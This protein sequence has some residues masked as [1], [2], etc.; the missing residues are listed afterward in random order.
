MP[1]LGVVCHAGR[2]HAP[3]RDACVKEAANRCLAR[4]ETIHRSLALPVKIAVVMPPSPISTSPSPR[5]RLPR[6]ATGVVAVR[7]PR[8]QGRRRASPGSG[9]TPIGNVRRAVI[10][11]GR[12]KIHRAQ[13]T[14]GSHRRSA[15]RRMSSTVA[16]WRFHPLVRERPTSIVGDGCAVREA[17][18][19]IC[20]VPNH[21]PEAGVGDAITGAREDPSTRR[22]R[23]PPIAPTAGQPSADCLVSLLQCHTGLPR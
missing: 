14:S 15:A 7:L 11:T 16:S 20:V 3:A 2:T 23:G 17:S 4:T 22:G 5:T 6:S 18:A 13:G 10:D 12:T 21:K 1:P 9:I 19:E 8:P